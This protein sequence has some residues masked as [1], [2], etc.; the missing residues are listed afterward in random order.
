MNDLLLSKPIQQFL[1]YTITEDIGDGDHTSLSC[2]PPDAVGEAVLLVKDK[3]V[4]AGIALAE[5]LFHKID[6]LLHFTGH[7]EEGSVVQPGMEA[8]TIAGS[9]RHILTAERLVLNFMQRMS[10]IATLTHAFVQALAGSSTRILDT[11]KTTPGLRFFEKWA[12]RIGGGTNHRFG[13]YDMIMIKDNHVDFAGGLEA[14]I[15][16]VRNYLIEH[17]LDLKI[18]VETRNLGELE[19]VLKIGGVDVVM[20][21]NYSFADTQTAVAWIDNTLECESS[22]NITLDTAP[23]YAA[24]GVDYISSGALTH[25]VKSLDLSLKARF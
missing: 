25:S 22:G 1:E 6:P 20:L 15:C 14:A 13:L 17:Q 5:H 18:E 23:Q 12:V 7:L 10:G 4:L 16:R 2:I 24:C 21:D 9:A 11:R 19:E 3:G 8:F